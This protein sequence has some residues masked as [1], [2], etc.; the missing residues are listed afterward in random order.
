MVCDGLSV[1]RSLKKKISRVDWWQR[2][3][4]WDEAKAKKLPKISPAPPLIL[5]RCVSL[6]MFSFFL[7]FSICVCMPIAHAREK[8]PERWSDRCVILGQARQRK[9]TWLVRQFSFDLFDFSFFFSVV[10]SCLFPLLVCFKSLSLSIF[11][12]LYFF[13]ECARAR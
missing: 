4:W 10:R 3:W 6:C 1:H 7:V 5:L 8:N 9:A 2:W 13:R 12:F 11:I